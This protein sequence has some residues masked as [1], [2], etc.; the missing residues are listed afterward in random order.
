MSFTHTI[1]KKWSDA[2]GNSKL[3]SVELT[4]GK[5]QSISESIA[6]SET[7]ALVNLNI[8]FSE[9]QSLYI[10]SD[11]A[12]T[13]ETNNGTTPDDT[14][15]LVAGVPLIW[16]AGDLQSCPLTAD[17]TALYVTNASGSAALLE[18]EVLEDSTTPRLPS[19]PAPVIPTQ[20]VDPGGKRSVSPN[21]SM[22]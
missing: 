7:D 22:P 8:D 5:Q 11:Q 14:F 2:L 10:K 15:V 3:G 19:G 6:D 21:R 12:I 4:G 20:V 13:L 18:I 1:T 16:H 17:V 9:L